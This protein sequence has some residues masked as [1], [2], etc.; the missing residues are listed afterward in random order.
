MDTHSRQI[1]SP[2]LVI[3]SWKAVFE[4]YIVNT[5]LYG[6]KQYKN[7][8]LRNSV[9]IIHLFIVLKLFF[10]HIAVK[11]NVFTSC[12]ISMYFHIHTCSK[13]IRHTIPMQ[14]VRS[15]WGREVS[16]TKFI[17]MYEK[18]IYPIGIDDIISL[19]IDWIRCIHKKVIDIIS[20]LY[21]LKY[22]AYP[23]INSY[24]LFVFTIFGQNISYSVCISVVC[25]CFSGFHHKIT[26]S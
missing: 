23:V 19:L 13:P 26:Y 10:F 25:S 17:F 2:A 5:S 18:F 21:L 8:I 16:S 3:W 22:K 11:Y 12:I 24:F 15:F 6:S 1:G 9:I 20:L 4:L 7:E 14:A